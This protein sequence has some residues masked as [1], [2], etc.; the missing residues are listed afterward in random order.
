MPNG[1]YID[2]LWAMYF[3]EL[4]THDN[5]RTGFISVTQ[6]N[7]KFMISR[8]LKFECTNNIAEMKHSC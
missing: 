5:S 8:C 1:P 4:K 7:R 2:K 3:D 6:N